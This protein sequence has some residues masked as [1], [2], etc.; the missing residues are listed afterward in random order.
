MAVKAFEPEVPESSVVDKLDE[1]KR[2]LTD[3]LGKVGLLLSDVE[4][5]SSCKSGDEFIL[6]GFI[7][8]PERKVVRTPGGA[9]LGS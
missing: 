1:L 8:R 2:A 9:V 4:I 6:C 3:E 5:R 7:A